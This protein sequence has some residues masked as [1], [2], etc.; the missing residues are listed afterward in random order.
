M[1]KSRIFTVGFELPGDEFEYVE[2]HSDQTLL[3][4]DII[5]FEPTL[6]I[7]S[8]EKYYNGKPLLTENS[9]FATKDRLDHWQ[10]EIISAVKAGKVVI[11]YLAKPVECFRHTGDKQFSGTGRSRVATNLVTGISSYEAVP[12]LTVVTSKSGK[13]IR[14]EPDAPFLGPYWPEFSNYSPYEVKIV[15]NFK[16]LLLKP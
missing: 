6:G 8:S 12:Y 1:A 3:D 11:V 16:Q 9:S 4:A 7:F 13:K 2:F 15:G 10:S 14:I 5:L